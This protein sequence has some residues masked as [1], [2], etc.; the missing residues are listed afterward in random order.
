MSQY[1]KDQSVL[2]G[3]LVGLF[4]FG[5]IFT[6]CCPNSKNRGEKQK[7]SIVSTT[8]IDNS[9]YRKVTTV[10]HDNHLFIVYGTGSQSA[11]IMH[12]PDCACGK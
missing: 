5:T 10:K 1:H 2:I 4:V 12:H 9:T 8:A 6:G 7:T 3:L 11:A